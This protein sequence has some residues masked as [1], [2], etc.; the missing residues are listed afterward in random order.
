MVWISAT[1]DGFC[2][3]GPRHAEFIPPVSPGLQ[4]QLRGMSG[5]ALPGVYPVIT[6]AALNMGADSRG[7]V[8]GRFYPTHA[9][10]PFTVGTVTI[11]V[12]DAVH[13]RARLDTAFDGGRLTGWF[14]AQRCP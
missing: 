3:P 8:W 12:N 11:E 7:K 1:E 10:L 5:E 6:D 14:D 2:D 9:G 13:L 4:L